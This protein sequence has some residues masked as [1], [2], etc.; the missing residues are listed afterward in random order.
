MNERERR[1][2]MGET[3]GLLYNLNVILTIGSG[4]F[5]QNL[6]STFQLYLDAGQRFFLNAK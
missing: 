6:F 2:E 5:L 3:L 4:D 1:R